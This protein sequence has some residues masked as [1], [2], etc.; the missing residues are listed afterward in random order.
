[1]GNHPR[2]HRPLEL[3]TKHPPSVG[4]PSIVQ[5]GMISGTSRSAGRWPAL[6]L[7]V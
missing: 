5:L 4:Y 1:M 3:R 7:C 2:D 6:D